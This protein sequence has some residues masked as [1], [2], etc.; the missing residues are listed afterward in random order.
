[1]GG[2]LSLWCDFVEESLPSFTLNA[3]FMTSFFKNL[4]FLM[5][6]IRSYGLSMQIRKF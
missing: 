3:P 1:M 6:G 5:Q 2:K 4:F